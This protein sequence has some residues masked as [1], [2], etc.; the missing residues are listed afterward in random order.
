MKRKALSIILALVS[1]SLIFALASCNLTKDSEK[2]SLKQIYK[3]LQKADCVDSYMMNGDEESRILL[4]DI[5]GEEI[6]S[7][8]ENKLEGA[9]WAE[10]NDWMVAVFECESG[11]AANQLASTASE[12]KIQN[13]FY[14][15]EECFCVTSRFFL[16]GTSVE[17][18]DVAL[19]NKSYDDIN[20]Q[21]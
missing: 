13:G 3:N 16:I 15:N 8:Y 17:I 10:G 4:Y 12:F 6:G 11:S 18:V 9:L 19:G 20:N 21:K 2:L 1:I 5:F 7:L 14:G